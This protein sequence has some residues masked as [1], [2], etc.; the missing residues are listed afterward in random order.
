MHVLRAGC[1][2]LPLALFGGLVALL[3]LLLAACSDEPSPTPTPGPPPAPTVA[4]T[5]TPVPT[6]TPAPT[7]EPTPTPAPTPT[8]KPTATP[9]PVPTPTPTPTPIPP[10]PDMVVDP[11]TAS[12]SSPIV[13]QPFTVEVT[14]RN[15]G[16]GASAPTTLR[17][18]RSTDST[19]TSGDD[20]VGSVPVPGLDASASST[21][22]VMTD[23]PPLAGTYYYGACAAPVSH[24]SDTTNNCSDAVAVDV[25][26]PPPDLAV[27]RPTVS[28]GAPITGQG[29]TVEVTVRNQGAGPSASTMLRF[30]R[31]TDST[32]TSGDDEVSAVLVPALSASASSTASVMTD[33]PPLTGTY[34][35]G[36]C[37][38][39]VS[40]ES[41]TAN[42]CSAA[43]AVDVL[44]PT[45]LPFPVSRRLGS[46]DLERLFDEIISKTEQ[47]EAF[48]EV[49]EANVGFSALADMKKLRS[50]FIA[51]ETELE[52]YYA[53]VKLSNARRDRHLRVL[54]VTGGLAFPQQR[55]ASA[56]IQVLP[57]LS[58][59][60]DPAFFV[61][62]VGGGVLSL[63]PGDT[64]VGVNG[65]PI[66]EYVM[67]FTPWIN[68]STLHGL[69][70]HMAYELPKRVS[71][72][73]PNLYSQRLNL[74]L[75]SPSGERYYVSLPYSDS[76]YSLGLIGSYPGF[77]EV[78]KRENFN[79]LVD[80]RRQ[81][82]LLEWL[83]FERD[84][85]IR[86]IPALMAYAEREGIL[87]YDIIIDVTR[88]G[89]GAF[90]AYVI[91]RLVD[92]P[93]RTTFGNVRL[94]DLG[95]ER[96]RRYSNRNA[97]VGAPE[98]F[99][100]NLSRS[101]LYHWA[102]TDATEAIRRGDEYTAPVPFKLAHLPKDSDGILQPAHVHFS[103]Q[104]AIIK[105]GVWGGSHLDQFLAMFVDNDLATF[106]GMPTGGFSNTWEGEEILRFPGAG[107][108]P[109]VEFM[110]SIGHTIRPNGEVLEGNPAQP[111]LYIPITAQN[112]RHY[113]Q[114]LL[115]TALDTL[116]AEV[117]ISGLVSGPDGKP[118]EGIG[119]WPR[120]E[121]VSISLDL[122]DS[123][124]SQGVFVIDVP[125]G[126]FA[127]RVYAGPGCSL[128]GWYDGA[129]GITTERDQAFTVIVDGASVEGI[130]IRLPAKPDD[131]PRVGPCAPD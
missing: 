32:I 37:V 5:P 4:P 80:Q 113:H 106:I 42:N 123:T 46:V 54:P 103:G 97:D 68:H 71:H 61:A 24:E 84:T 47:R 81:V 17:Y 53:L 72:V 122:F 25:L 99:G 108:R 128:V 125:D 126:S 55:C 43:V 91:Q 15:Q 82:I 124:D 129:G 33:A 111:D 70:W 19:V 79:V 85:L 10:R 51:S 102:R 130:E 12:D 52:L 59:I 41:D 109:V 93:F 11:A 105:A 92:Q 23:A 36:A 76:C 27:D 118:L 115:G 121:P 89:G 66:S 112:Y 21:A 96:V 119:I 1:H 60:N 83:D 114:D 14:V 31:S 98:I 44:P 104:V 34:Y 77:V 78:M 9:T 101:W 58:N 48:S 62:A 40:R 116:G 57:D 86:D 95:R 69:Y 87:Q 26:P 65:R 8:P 7:P 100:L 67:E 30:Y 13:G 2:G 18:Y 49:K 35:Y 29:I 131:L 3:A 20:E 28:D 120:G 90:G 56:P 22:S 38:A 6:P 39:P 64:I 110:W 107:G 127:L 50:E 63:K 45:P 73:P 16:A 94:S 74:A 88:S 75:E 117:S